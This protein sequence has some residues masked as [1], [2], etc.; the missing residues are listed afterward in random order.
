M[1][2]LCAEGLEAHVLPSAGGSV[3]RFDRVIGGERRELFRGTYNETATALQCGC[4]PL[5][6]YCNRIRNGRFAFRSRTVELAPNM[7]PDPSP[8]HGQGWLGE[9]ELVADSPAAVE[10]RFAHEPGEW[11]WAW[12]G[13]QVIALDPGG[14][15]IELACRNLSDEP[16]PCGLGLHPF[17][18]CD[19]ATRLK[20]TVTGA[21]TVDAAVLPVEHVA[22]AARFDLTDRAICGQDLDNGF[23]GWSG[24]ALIRWDDGTG[25]RLTSPDAGFF[26]VYSPSEGGLFVA[27]PVQHANCAL[28]EPEAE[29]ARLGLA[30]LA[31]GEDRV[32]RARFGVVDLAEPARSPPSRLR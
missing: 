3:A 25:L 14:L 29:W 4:F 28:N 16:M 17:Y 7:P 24:E 18:P 2:V 8:L 13:R 9:W 12:E 30:V 20:T 19:G 27:E 31:P 26:Q 32:L 10:L 22:A 15:S 21:W 6:P 5:V 11:P 23:D 1:I